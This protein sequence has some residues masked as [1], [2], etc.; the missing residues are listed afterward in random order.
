MKYSFII[1]PLLIL[2]MDIQAQI[3]K[4]TGSLFQEISNHISTM[5]GDSGLDYRE[6]TNRELKT[7]E[8]TIQN[9]LATHYQA[10]GDSAQKVGYELLEFSD[11]TSG[12][13]KLYYLLQ[14]QDS[15]HWG[16]Y[17]YNPH[18]CRP[19]VIQSPHAK[20]DANTGLQGAY[21]FMETGAM[22]FEVNGTHRCNSSSPSTCSG[23]TT[24][25]SSNSS[26]RPYPI[27][28]LS[29]TT[30]SLFQKTT[31][32]IF[33]E[34]D[35]SF[36]IQLHGFAKKSS[37][38]YVILSNGTQQTPSTDYLDDF[39]INLFMIDP[40]LTF[41]VAHIDTTWTRLR[42][43]LNTQG[44][45]INSSSDP[46]QSNATQTSGRF[47]HIE[48]ERSKL[49]DNE[50]GWTKI[51]EALKRSFHCQ[52]LSQLERGSIN[53]L[54]V[55]P[56]PAEDYVQIV[57]LNGRS[58]DPSAFIF[59]AMGQN[60]SKEVIIHDSRGLMKLDISALSPGVYWIKL[61]HESF[62]ILKR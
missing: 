47:F 16:A 19:L 60:V 29:H 37:D 3:V 26:S 6:P 43:F 12:Q 40:S 27:S 53:R 30:Q 28:D 34:I 42:G 11:T 23:S 15:N 55:Y 58:F 25:C 61:E 44:R 18:Y 2:G 31:E 9:L 5:P 57:G 7:W 59:S 52:S 46:C 62:K 50:A 36:F 56:N 8:H 41:K 14:T 22:F 24:V 54:H 21:I 17:I 38:P 10:A 32:V 4:K 45:Y 20:K 13:N 49:R 35:K 1:L 51:A 33:Q 39:R 48:Q